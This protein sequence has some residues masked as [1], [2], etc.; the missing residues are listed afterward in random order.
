MTYSEGVGDGGGMYPELNGS[1]GVLSLTSSVVS[2][3]KV[4]LWRIL[5][6]VASDESSLSF[7]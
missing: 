4:I 5:G 1:K 3:S 6:V 7:S 2:F